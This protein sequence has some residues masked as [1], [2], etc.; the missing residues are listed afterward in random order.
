MGASSRMEGDP[1]ERFSQ[2]EI[3]RFAQRYI[4]RIYSEDRLTQPF[5]PHG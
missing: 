3:T 5:A 4:E 2:G 1:S